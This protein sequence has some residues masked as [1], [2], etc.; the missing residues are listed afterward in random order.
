MK[1][2]HKDTIWSLVILLCIGTSLQD[3][4]PNSPLFS[5]NSLENKLYVTILW[6]TE[7][8]FRQI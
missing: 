6:K 4:T 2:N 3:C 7:V 5:L 1:S 8:I